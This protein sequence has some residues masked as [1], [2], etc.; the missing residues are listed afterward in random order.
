MSLLRRHL[1][2]A[3]AVFLVLASVAAL[4]ADIIGVAFGLGPQGPFLSVTPQAAVGFI[5]A[6]GLALII[7]VALWRATPARAWNFGA[8]AVH[9]LLGGANLVFWPFFEA[10]DLLAVGYVT[11]GFHGLFVLLH[12]YA[13][14]G[15]R[16]G[17]T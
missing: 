17:S 16:I 9:L 10:A 7:G 13:V 14:F 4:H 3:N 8:M 6:H 15:R 11:T 5:E 12:S 1:L 2:R